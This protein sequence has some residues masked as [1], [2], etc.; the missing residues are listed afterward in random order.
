MPLPPDFATFW[1][2]AAERDY[3][4]RIASVGKALLFPSF[5]EAMGSAAGVSTEVW[6][7]PGHPFTSSLTG[8]SAAQLAEDYQAGRAGSGS[9]RIGFVHAL[10]EVAAS[11][12]KRVG[13][14]ADKQ[15]LADAIKATSLS[16]IVGKVDWSRRPGRLPQRVQDPAGRGPV[17]QG[18][19]PG[20]SSW[21]SSPTPST[22]RSRPP[23]RCSR[24]T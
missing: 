9:S 14:V 2:Q 23:A 16:T 22:P 8:A 10:F 5:I 18:H 20:R 1:K 19:A 4:P 24:S 3:R 21:R 7:S 6:W 11:V 15:A 17:A 12:L 13:D